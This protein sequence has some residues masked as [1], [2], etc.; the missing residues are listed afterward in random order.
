M[1]IKLSFIEKGSGFPLILLHGNGEEQGYFKHQ[2]DYFSDFF[3]VIAID[4]RGHGQSPRGEMPF[5][6]SQFADDLYEFIQE[7][8]IKKAHILGFSDGGNIALKFTLK[9][10]EFVEKLILNGANLDPSG[11]K[12]T[13]QIPIEIGY[14][15]ASFFAA[16]SENAKRNA[17]MLGLMVNDPF[18]DAESLAKIKCEAL[19]IAGTKDLILERH[20]RL[21]A[22][23]I[24]N[25]DLVF[26][27]GDH[28][29][30]AKNPLAFNKAVK[31]FLDK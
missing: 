27:K 7:Q 12:K 8:K 1:D 24:E 25:S 6:I 31:D 30:A 11:V 28:F 19:V 15:I 9:Y 20:S 13:A 17:E 16:K 29:V 22:N 2:I 3:R 4:T 21:I 18:I 23:R 14:K 10:P 26:I 5:T